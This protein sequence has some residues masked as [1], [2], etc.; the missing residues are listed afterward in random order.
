MWIFAYGSL[1]FRPSFPYL[2][3]RAAWV[4]G[5]ARRFWQ[6]SPDHRGTPEAPGRVATLVPLEG[7]AC[8]GC[9]YRID[10]SG[11]DEI[12]AALDHREQAG[13]DRIVLVLLDSARGEPFAEALTYVARQDNPH[14]LGPLDERAIALHVASSHGPSGA[15]REYV[16]RLH[17]ALR[18]LAIADP[19]VDAT[20]HWLCTHVGA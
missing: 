13:F 8:G 17:A 1:V 4:S 7:E 20:V 19:H 2:E 12:L 6:G 9:A 15:N 16:L 18:E 3:R 11:S 5:H 10:P 14:F